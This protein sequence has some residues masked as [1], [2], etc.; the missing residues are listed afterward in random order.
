MTTI[1]TYPWALQQYG[2]GTELDSLREKGVDSVA[3]AAHYHSIQTFDPRAPSEK[4]VQYPG[5]CYFDPE[6]TDFE[7][8]S[9]EPMANTIPGMEDPL[10]TVREATASRDLGL[11]AWMVCLHNTRLGT[12]HPGF[13]I[14]SAFGDVHEHSLCPSHPTVQEYYAGIVRS[15]CRY[16]VDRID[17]ES[18]GFPSVLH[19]HGTDYGH[20]KNQ[21]LTSDAEEFLLSQCFCDGCRRRA[22]V[23]N[24]DMDAAETL[25][26]ELLERSISGPQARPTDLSTLVEEYSLLEDIFELRA[27]IIERLLS[28]LASAGG[29]TP[30]NYYVADG[31]GYEAGDGWPAGVQLGR[32]RKHLD[33]VTAMCYTTEPS[34]IRRRIEG[35][36]SAVSC[37]VNAAVTFDPAI[38]PDRETFSSI[39]RTASDT[40]S[41]ELY[42]YNHGLLGID[43]LDWLE[44]VVDRTSA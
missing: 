7:S 28:K 44:E 3:L 4:F 30:L 26:Q 17:L 1:F 31:I 33:S 37:P 40:A 22:D 39:A 38:S 41:G 15:L 8:T 19:G 42:L 32:L 9:I 16:G 43:Q 12:E 13:R 27:V 6:P 24:L 2:V 35:L 36:D 29:R 5:G 14:Q 21:V 25:V 23:V 34:T 18:L 11:V 10:S 20:S